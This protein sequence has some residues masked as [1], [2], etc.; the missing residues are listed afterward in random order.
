V[1]GFSQTAL[2]KAIGVI[3]QQVQK[4]DKGTNRV[5]A[6]R[7]QGIANVLKVAPDFF[8]KETQAKKTGS[9]GSNETTLIDEFISSR[10]RIALAQAD[11]QSENATHDRLAD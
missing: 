6:S 1:R 2:G 5:S 8:F 11:Q 4:Y 10:E 3:F 7:L 9:S